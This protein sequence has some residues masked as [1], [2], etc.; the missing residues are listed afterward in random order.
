M[1]T[2]RVE[3]PSAQRPDNQGVLDREDAKVV[4]EF[5]GGVDGWG[6]R[7]ENVHHD[8]GVACDNRVRVDGRPAIHDGIRLVIRV[9]I[10]FDGD[11]VGQSLAVQSNP[12]NS[13]VECGP[14]P[15]L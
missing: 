13:S 3:M 15:A 2:M 11:P 4:D 10:H 1:L 9:V 14:Y 5:V 6:G 8:D 12:A 7:G